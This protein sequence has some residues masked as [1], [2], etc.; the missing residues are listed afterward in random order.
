MPNTELLT[1][2][3]VAELLRCSVWT[4][5][6]FPAAVLPVV[7]KAP[8]LRGAKFYRRSDIEL[9]LAKKAS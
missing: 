6:R 5:A 9:L 2:R 7:V 8:G 4:V 3:E 1:S